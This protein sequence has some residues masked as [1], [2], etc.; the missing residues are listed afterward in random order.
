MPQE[1]IIIKFEPKGHPELIAAIKKLNVETKKLTGKGGL[2]GTTVAAKKFSNAAANLT[3]KLKVQNITWKQ[4]GVSSEILKKAYQG[5]RVA[6][7]KLRIAMARANK[8]GMMNVRNTR[9]LDMA[10]SVLRSKLLLLAFAYTLIGRHIAE[11]VK[12][13]TIQQD[14]EKALESAL[15]RTSQALLDFASAQ[16]K[17]TTFGD[18]NT[19]QAMATIGAYTD[20]EDQIKA[21]T[22]A[23]M[24]LATGKG[25]DLVAAADMLTKSVFSTTNA[26]QRYGVTVR[27]MVGSTGRLETA[28]ESIAA[29]FGGRATAASETLSGS[30]SQLSNSLGDLAENLVESSPVTQGTFILTKAMTGLIDKINESDSG[31]DIFNKAIVRTALSTSMLGRI[32]FEV[33]DMFGLFDEKVDLSTETNEKHRIKLLEVAEAQNKY[34]T[35]ARRL[36]EVKE[37]MPD[38]DQKISDLTSRRIELVQLEKDGLIDLIAL[39]TQL[40]DI[41]A[42][43]H[44]LKLQRALKLSQTE[45]KTTADAVKSGAALMGLNRRNLKEMAVLQAAAAMIDAWAAAQS[46]YAMVSKIAPPPFPQ[47]AYAAAIAQ[48]IAQAGQVTKAAGIFEQGGLIGGRRHSQ[49]GTMINAERGEFVMSRNAVESIGLENLNQMNEGGGSSNITLNISAP[50]VDDTV[51]DSII[52]AIREAVR[53]GEDIGIS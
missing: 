52:P 34:T 19:I 14:A 23:S 20:E 49:G 29:L 22:T 45:K 40:N 7:E 41:D 30:F 48:G 43:V 32:I 38:I 21:L 9:N 39:N 4:L 25:M 3:A 53:R 44:T 5:N 27:G 42:K 24:D 35:S 10:F 50:L 51:V 2:G 15:G 36:M 47:I 11:M 13:F 8:Q 46:Q 1:K 26:L 12:K 6:L 31:F 37:G 33:G 18:E 17:V 28:T 16:Q